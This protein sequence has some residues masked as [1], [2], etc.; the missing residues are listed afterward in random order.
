MLNAKKILLVLVFVILC[1]IPFQ[2]VFAYP[3]GLLD[4]K[5]VHRGGDQN[6][7]STTN[8]GMTDSNTTTSTQL[9]AGG[10]SKVIW[11]GGTTEKIG[12]GIVDSYKL[13]AASNGTFVIRFYNNLGSVIHEISNPVRDGSSVPIS[14]SNIYKVAIHNTSSELINIYEFD[15][16]APTVKTD[17]KSIDVDSI[18]Q[19]SAEV[20]WT[21]PTDFSGVGYTGAKIYLNGILKANSNSTNTSYSLIGLTKETSYTIKVTAIYSDGSE[22]VGKEKTFKTLGDPP[23]LTPPS[24]PTGL[25]AE[26]DGSAV[27]LTFNANTESDLDYYNIYRDGTKLGTVKTNSFQDR[28]ARDGKTYTYEVSAVDKAGNA[29]EKSDV[30]AISIAE[31]LDVN[32]IPNADSIVV[33]IAEGNAPYTIKWGAQTKTVDVTSY[34]IEGLTLNTDYVVTVTD[35]EGLTATKS[36][37]T[38]NTKN[39]IPPLMPNPSMMFQKMLDSFSDAGIVAVA[40]IGAAVSLG[41]LTVLGI[42]AWRSFRKWLASA[43]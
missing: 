19:T 27:N 18:E 23:D 42:F 20:T 35:K 36:I 31:V 5:L 28:S 13:N 1:F 11:Y 33:Q 12:S 43:K 41:I 9:A 7:S 26:Y 40:L 22:T 17:I 2:S 16:F 37:N 6:T 21:N 14:V 25:I 32:F 34:K 15:I 10:T 39:Y 24:K 4:G 3:G 38:G 8:T 30:F 29:S